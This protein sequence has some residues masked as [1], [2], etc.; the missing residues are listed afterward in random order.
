[1][2]GMEYKI[3]GV[4]MGNPHAVV[5]LEDVEKLDISDNRIQHCEALKH[6]KKLR[7]F[8]ASSC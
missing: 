8:K 6:M 4:S 2:D 3:T 1:V 7:Y 5:F